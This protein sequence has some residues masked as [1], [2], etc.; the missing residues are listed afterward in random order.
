MVQQQVQLHKGDGEVRR[1]RR[2]TNQQQVL[3]EANENH[4]KNDPQT[5]A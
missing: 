2:L 3:T 5:K 4:G 1:T